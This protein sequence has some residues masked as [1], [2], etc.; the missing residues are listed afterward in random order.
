[1]KWFKWGL[2]LLFSAILVFITVAYFAITSAATDNLPTLDGEIN[3]SAISKPVSLSR[4]VLGQAVISA[5]SQDDAVYALGYAHA[6]A[7]YFQ[8]DMLRR[9]GAG[10]VSFLLSSMA[11]EMDIEMRFHQLKKRSRAIYANLPIEQKNLLE[12]YAKGVNAGRKSTGAPFEYTV[13]MA[14]Q[15]PWHPADS[16]LV[17]YAMFYNLQKDTITRDE[18]LIYLA[19]EY[20]QEMID[21]IM[22][23]TDFQAALDG[24]ELDKVVQRIPDINSSAVAQV[25]EISP[26]EAAG[27]NNWAVTGELTHTGY[28]MVSDDMHLNLGVPIIW[29]RAQMN[30]QHQGSDVQV[31]GVTLPGVPAVVVGS[32]GKIAWGFTNSFVDTADWIALSD[33][34]KT[35]VESDNI[36]LADGE[37]YPFEVTL[38]KYGPVKEING[39][40]YALNWVGH[41]AFAVNA[42]LAEL[43]HMD[44]L[45]ETFSLIDHIGIPTQNFVAVDAQGHLIIYAIA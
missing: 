32:N 9:V 37:E 44:T 2:G 29:Y 33:E 28:A 36:P 4:D 23:P 22:Q 10:E 27:S 30:Y 8:M 42:K 18:T 24:S 6:Q 35:T 26:V 3:T 39:Q 1:M 16:L 45:D 25:Y 12:S 20:G 15:L 41:H 43:A 5:M 21:F 14:E 17:I 7:R 40:R 34:D 13:M 11:V 31:T 38:S 19:D